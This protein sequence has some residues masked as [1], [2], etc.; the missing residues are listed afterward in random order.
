M[1]PITD[2]I[3]VTVHGC[4]T[5][6][7]VGHP[8]SH[9]FH[10]YVGYVFVKESASLFVNMTSGV[11]SLGRFNEKSCVLFFS[12]PVWWLLIKGMGDR[13]S[14]P[15]LWLVYWTDS[16]TWQETNVHNAPHIDLHYNKNRH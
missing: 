8:V 3:I 1:V 11:H 12:V 4:V 13:V 16:L 2:I 10:T 14:D 15:L 5:W 6:H 7:R 9:A